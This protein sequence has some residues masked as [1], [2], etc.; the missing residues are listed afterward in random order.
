[1]GSG[2]GAQAYGW[3]WYSAQAQDVA[4]GYQTTLTADRGFD[5]GGKSGLT[6]EQVQDLVNARE[7]KKYLDGVSLPSGVADRVIDDIVYGSK[8]RPL[9]RQYLSLIHI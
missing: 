4:K 9:P 7:G 6:R 3:G 8:G 2:E 5:F 1:M